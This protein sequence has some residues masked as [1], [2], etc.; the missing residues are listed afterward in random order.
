M[1]WI[2]L[3]YCLVV[4]VFILL[5]KSPVPAIT[6]KCLK[7]VSDLPDSFVIQGD[8]IRSGMES[9]PLQTDSLKRSGV[10]F[11]NYG[12]RPFNHLDSMLLFRPDS[13]LNAY[14]KKQQLKVIRL[15]AEGKIPIGFFN[16]DYNKLFGYN[17]FE[18]V[19]LGLGGETNG[20]LSHHFSIGGAFS[21]GLKNRSIQ[22]GE[23]ICLL[24][25]SPSPRD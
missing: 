8:T 25:T 16:L 1:N 7:S 2:N 13:A 17:L 11:R 22:Q 9:I 5:L 23:W 14:R 24:Y 19:K 10:L 3:K 15:M 20:K 21:Y 6:T 18:G 12:F 4:L